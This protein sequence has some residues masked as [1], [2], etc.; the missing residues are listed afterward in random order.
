MLL[1]AWVRLPALPW[2]WFTDSIHTA[3]NSSLHCCYNQFSW[4]LL[5]CVLRSAF[6]LWLPLLLLTYAAWIARL[7]V[8]LHNIPPPN[9]SRKPWNLEKNLF[10]L[11]VVRIHAVYRIFGWVD[12]STY[13]TILYT[14]LLII[15]VIKLVSARLY[16]FLYLEGRRYLSQFWDSSRLV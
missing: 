1:L 10:F 13:S 7:I 15:S 5:K 12:V 14:N 6:V 8:Y 3:I 11:A 2:G 9:Q 4:Y 16:C